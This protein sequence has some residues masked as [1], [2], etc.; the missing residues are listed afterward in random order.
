MATVEERPVALERTAGSDQAATA[1][2]VTAFQTYRDLFASEALR[3]GQPISVGVLTVV[4]T[5]L[6]GSTRYYREI[7]V[8]PAFGSVLAHVDALRDAVAGDGGAVV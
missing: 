6:R 8:A 1:A 4:F 3:P 5:D 2:E 7:G